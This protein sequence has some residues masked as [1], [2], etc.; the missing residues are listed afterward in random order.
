LEVGPKSLVE[1]HD[2]KDKRAEK[3]KKVGR[4]ERQETERG[5]ENHRVEE[6]TRKGP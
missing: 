3:S 4:V 1:N 5:E 6:K 2:A